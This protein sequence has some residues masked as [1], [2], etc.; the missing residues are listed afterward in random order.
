MQIVATNPK[1]LKPEDISTED[2]EQE[3]NIYRE[4]LEKSGKP[5]DIIE[6]AMEGKITKFREENA[7]LTQAYIKDPTRKVDDIV[8]D[9]VGK[10]GENIQIGKFCRFQI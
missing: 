4:Q 2:L 1:A 3:K 7:L 6:K 8:K 10:V 9:I 5:A